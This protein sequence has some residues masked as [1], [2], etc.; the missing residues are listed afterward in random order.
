MDL[1]FTIHNLASTAFLSNG[2]IN[3]NAELIAKQRARDCRAA[4]D[5]S[6]SYLAQSREPRVVGARSSCPDR[7]ATTLAL[8]LVS[9]IAAELV[10]LSLTIERARTSITGAKTASRLQRD[11]PRAAASGLARFSPS[12]SVPSRCAAP[13]IDTSIFRRSP[14]N[15]IAPAHFRVYKRSLTVST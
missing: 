3:R 14:E 12:R 7:G 10:G 8:D 13:L 5:R 6:L 1:P 15:L 4:T 11:N 2:P 9:P